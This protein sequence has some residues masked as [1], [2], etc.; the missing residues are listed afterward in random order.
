MWFGRSKAQRSH[1]HA[2]PPLKLVH[3]L[4][5]LNTRRGF[6]FVDFATK[7]EARNAMEGVAGAHLYGRRLVLEWAE[8][9]GGLDEL[10]AKTAAR[11]RAEQGPGGEA[12]LGMGAATEGMEEEM[13]EVAG[14]APRGAGG[15]RPAKKQRRK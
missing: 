8:E 10:R 12:G 9:E 11:S 13:E 4:P 7:Q 14:A 15:R 2:L 3:A 5:P 1:F 6:A